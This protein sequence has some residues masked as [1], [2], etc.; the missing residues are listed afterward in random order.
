MFGVL[1]GVFGFGFVSILK[2]HEFSGVLDRELADERVL[3]EFGGVLG[4]PFEEGHGNL[5]SLKLD[6]GV[7][8]GLFAFEG[9]EH[10][11]ALNK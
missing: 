4:D 1:V 8:G 9:L 5:M 7:T 11:F 6:E 3:H 2:F 10:Q